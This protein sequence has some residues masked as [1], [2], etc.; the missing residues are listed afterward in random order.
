[1]D[2]N[3]LRNK[4]LLYVY[5]SKNINN[6]VSKIS[7]PQHRDDLKSHLCLQLMDIN[8][9]KLKSLYYKNKIEFY[10]ISILKNEYRNKNS[11]FYKLYRI[12]YDELNSNIIELY[13][14]IDNSEDKYI[15]FDKIMNQLRFVRPDKS[16]VFEMY[17]IK[18][19][20]YEEIS[21]L[22]GVNYLAIRR[23]VIDTVEFIKERLKN[24]K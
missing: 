1:M 13:N 9:N 10:C 16:I 23:R 8:L 14:D 12:N 22:T 6:A 21:E 24:D 11:K 19:M 3:K 17:Y 5:N 4:I 18:N 20:T 7:A 15:L 2:P